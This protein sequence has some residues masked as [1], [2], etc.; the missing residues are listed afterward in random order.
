M[1]FKKS[2]P[3]F[4]SVL[5]LISSA[6]AQTAD[7]KAAAVADEVMKAMGGEKVWNN[8]RHL[9]WNFF[10]ARTLTWDK[11]T[12]EVRIDVPKDETVYLLNVNTMKGKATEKGEEIT[13]ASELNK[14][15]EKAKGIWI[16]DSYWL[17]MPFKLQDPGV[18]LTYEGERATET[19]EMS[20]VL[21]LSFEN[22]GLTPQ[23][24]YLVFVDKNSR[25]VTQ[26]SFYRNASDEKPGFTL[27]WGDYK[28]YDKLMLS[29]ERG[30]RDLTDIKVFKKLPQSVYTSFEKPTL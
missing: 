21:G 3:I 25:L 7:P 29:G 13:D 20:D 1:T 28:A 23:N 5:F 6:I 19:G 11:Y 22:V 24:K 14:A 12:G 4:I 17:V 26:W 30:E 27:P 10:G 18:T 9:H 8:S 15:L 2:I 16:N